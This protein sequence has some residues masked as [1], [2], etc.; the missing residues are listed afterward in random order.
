MIKYRPA[1]RV[2]LGLLILFTSIFVWFLMVNY[3][4]TNSWAIKITLMPISYLLAGFMTMWPLGRMQGFLYQVAPGI[5][6]TQLERAAERYGVTI[7]EDS[8]ILG[9]RKTSS[10]L[11]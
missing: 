6:Q 8:E 9:V 4:D 3:L 10:W 7:T 5:Y 2:F 1:F 11:K